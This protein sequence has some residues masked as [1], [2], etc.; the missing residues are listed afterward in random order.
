MRSILNSLLGFMVTIVLIGCT[1]HRDLHV[2]AKPLFIVKNDWSE[3][4]LIPEGATAMFFARPDPKVPMLSDPTRHKLYLEPNIYDILVF[5]EVMLSSTD[6][7]LEGI[8]Y[9][10]TDKF[11]TFG[12]YAKPSQVN[13]IF[14]SAEDE[15]MVGYA[16]PEPLATRTEEQREILTEKEYVMK[17]QNGK[18]GFAVYRDYDADSTEFLPIRVTRKVKVI[19]HVRNFKKGIRVSGTLRGMAEGVLLATRQP[20]GAKATYVFDLN[21]AVVDPER[22]D[23]YIIVSPSFTTFGPWWNDYPSSRNYTLDLLVGKNG[24][25]FRYTFDVTKSDGE[26]VTRSV[27]DAILK[28]KVEE[29]QFLKDGTP[30]KMEE[31]IIEVW[32][33]LPTGTDGSIDVDLGD[34]GTDIIIPIPIG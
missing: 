15:V 14:K 23:G 18:N 17:Y 20:D 3:A 29:A 8:A 13:A 5:N 11:N 31:I 22:E 9:R 21:N 30:P 16:Y 6:S 1:D 26:T 24:D 28:I 12:A 2:D 19:A 33:A 4:R 34:W 27:G 32:L 7:N 10:G 25:T